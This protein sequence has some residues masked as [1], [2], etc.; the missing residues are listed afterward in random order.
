M[1]HTNLFISVALLTTLVHLSRVDA[2]QLLSTEH[3][4]HAAT[5]RANDLNCYECDTIK[6]GEH[7][8]NPNSNYTWLKKKCKDDRRQCMVKRYSFTLSTENSTSEPMMWALERNCTNKCEPG[9]IVIGERTKL[10]ACTDCC[11]KSYC[12]TGKGTAAD[13]TTREIGFVLTLVLQAVL[14]VTLYPA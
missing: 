12:N 10:F 9:C 5:E 11:E 13:L 1:H 2:G 4:T 7:C 3:R 14:T 8:V 6:D